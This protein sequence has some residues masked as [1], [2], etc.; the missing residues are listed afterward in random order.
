MW[1]QDFLEDSGSGHESTTK[2]DTTDD[3]DLI[4]FGSGSGDGSGVGKSKY[5]TQ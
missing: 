3:E 1:L 4:D 2:D 5:C